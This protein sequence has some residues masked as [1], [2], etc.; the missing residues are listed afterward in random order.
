MHYIKDPGDTLDYGWDWFEWLEG[1]TIATST[2]AIPAG[3]TNSGESG[4]VVL[5]NPDRVTTSVFISGGTV[6]V[7][8]TITNTITTS[9]TPARVKELSHTIEIR[10]R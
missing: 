8:Y 6:G 5:T 1:D 4:P 7:V 2:W 9:S 10:E 3:I